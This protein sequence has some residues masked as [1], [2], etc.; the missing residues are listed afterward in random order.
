VTLARCLSNTFAGIRPDDVPGFIAAQFAGAA[1]GTW[2]S[3]W[4]FR[5]ET[6]AKTG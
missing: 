4:I 6:Q 2:V 1:A 3:T 5:D